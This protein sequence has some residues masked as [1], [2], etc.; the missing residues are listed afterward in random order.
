MSYVGWD[1]FTLYTGEASTHLPLWRLYKINAFVALLTH[2]SVVLWCMWPLLCLAHII[3]ASAR[4]R[5]PLC[6]R[7]A[8][9]NPKKIARY[10]LPRLDAAESE[11]PAGPLAHDHP[12]F[13]VASASLASRPACLVVL[14]SRLPSPHRGER[15]PE[16]RLDFSIST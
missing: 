15:A 1:C 5:I 4:P 8:R 2:A 11:C 16:R 3:A 14:T 12:A 7:D 6:R 9:I 13:L 10:H